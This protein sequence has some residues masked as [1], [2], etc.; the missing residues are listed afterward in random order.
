MNNKTSKNNLENFKKL[1]RKSVF[2]NEKEEHVFF[3]ISDEIWENIFDK[4]F[5]SNFNYAQR[6]LLKEFSNIENIDFNGLKGVEKYKLDIFNLKKCSKLIVDSIEK[7]I[8]ILF[9]TD[10]DN[11]GSLSQA[12][13]NEFLKI[14]TNASSLNNISVEYANPTGGNQN[15][16]ITVDLIDKIVENKEWDKNKDFLIITADNG[17]N[18]REEQEKINK[19]YENAKIIITDHHNP[20]KDMVIQ[21]NEKTLIFNPKYK[22]TEF[23]KKYNISG[24]NTI[25]VLLKHV[26]ANRYSEQQLKQ[27]SMRLGIRNINKLSKVSN[28][29]DYVASHPADKPEKDYVVSK[30]LEL[31][32]LL[33]INNSINKMIDGEIN[34]DTLIYLK[35]KIKNLNVDKLIEEVKNIQVQNETAK[36]LLSIY[37]KT[38]EDKTILK[39]NFEKFFLKEFNLIFKQYENPFKLKDTDVNYISQLRPLIFN[40]TADDEKNIFLDKL[41]E[42]MISIYENIRISEKA[43]IQEIRNGEV[44]TKERLNNSCIIYANEHVLKVFNRKFLNKVY[45]DE[46]P[47]FM[48]TLD[49]ISNEKR[50]GSFRSLYDISDILKNKKKLEKK[51]NITIETP[52]HERAA[53]FIIRTKNKDKAPIT[54]NTIKQINEFINLEIEELKQQQVLNKKDF[55]LTDLENIQ[56]ID[57]INKTI[58]GNIPH[59]ERITPL[60]KITKDTIWSES[61]STQ[62]FTMEELIKNKSYGYITININFHQDTVIVPVEVLR[63]IVEN[64]YQE[65]LSL[66]Y[67]DAGVFMVERVVKPEEINNLIDV[68]EK[69]GK[70]KEIE[71][72]FEKDFKN[73]NLIELNRLQIKDNPF[74]K[75]HDYGQLN[76]DLFEKMVIGIIETNKVDVLSVFDVEANGFGNARLTNLGSMNYF[77]DEN[78]GMKVS[79]KEFFDFYFSTTRGEDFILNEMDTKDLKEIK[80]EDVESLSLEQKHCLLIKKFNELGDEKEIYQYF[81]FPENKLKTIGKK[82]RLPFE[83]NPDKEIHNFKEV[84]NEIIYNRSI[85]AEMLAYLIK[86]KDFKVGQE[87]INLTG[88]TQELLDKHG[89]ETKIVDEDFSN[90]YKEKKARLFGAHNTPY[91]ARIIRANMPKTYDIL[92]NSNIYDSALFSKEQQLAYDMIQCAVF[93]KG[94]IKG[95]DRNTIYFYHSDFSEFNLK[96]FIEKNENGYFP[97]RSGRYLLEINNSEYFLVDKEAHEKIKLEGK[98]AD[99]LKDKEIN[100][101]LSSINKKYMINDIK[102]SELTITPPGKVVASVLKKANKL[103]YKNLYAFPNKTDTFL[104]EEENGN[105]LI[106][107]EIEKYNKK[108]YEIIPL[109]DMKTEMLEAMEI[110]ALPKVA[111]KYSVEK[112][113]EQW[114]IRAL[115][116]SD[117]KFD[118]KFKDINQFSYPELIPYKKEIDFFQKNYHFDNLPEVNLQKF[119]DYAKKNNA[120]I[121]SITWDEE[122]L[123]KTFIQEFVELNKD[124]QKKFA[125]SWMYKKVL[126]I[127]DPNATEITEDLISMINYQTNIPKEKIKEIYQQAIEF[128]NKYKLKHVLQH[129]QHVNGLWETDVKGDIAFEDKLTLSMLAQR[130]YD[131]FDHDE[132]KA[133]KEFNI[134]QLNARKAFDIADLLSDDFAV[135]SYSYRQGLQYNRE[136]QTNLIA[137]IQEKETKSQNNEELEIKFK[138]GNDLLPQDYYITAIKRD[139]VNLNRKQI[140]EDQRMIQF[141]VLDRIVKNG[142]E[143]MKDETEVNTYTSEILEDNERLIQV[144]KEELYAR[145]RY[146]ELNDKDVNLKKMVDLAFEIMESDE[147][148]SKEDWDNKKTIKY[149]AELS[150]DS[151]CVQSESRNDGKIRIVDIPLNNIDKNDMK[152]IITIVENY[153][154]N[155]ER[156]SIKIEQPKEVL[157]WLNSIEKKLE[158]TPIEKVKIDKTIEFSQFGEIKEENFINNIENK[159]IKPYETIVNKF[160]EQRILNESVKEFIDRSYI[161]KRKKFVI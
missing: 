50:S 105:I 52:G 33:N 40:L 15:R 116:L 115:L 80:T 152:K 146:I 81:L 69:N 68:S 117:E 76:F 157:Q 46:N 156:L 128:K 45:N 36:V 144:Y 122:L 14:D 12:I 63:R 127:K 62:Q 71:N 83:K 65:Y 10:V 107:K 138:L 160:N 137:N 155:A 95:I 9:V 20:E 120:N 131:P 129:E 29:L 109:S 18:S 53:G 121:T 142:L 93:E 23:F 22:P 54:D 119:V 123:L 158:I 161:S 30:F 31:Q 49:G 150:D 48:L 58:R 61:Y 66:N 47:G 132:T 41:N 5:D 118:I 110:K 140:E 101:F 6:V 43:I 39:E 108:T 1:V 133:I 42:K 149:I 13:I 151:F 154:N 141:L 90:Y 124:I 64:N 82:K 100:G 135:D 91:D 57:K 153:I 92:K 11:D 17:I 96:K 85:K 24:A 130:N 60:I 27:D 16:G 87:V 86:D 112:M 7:K 67:M 25:S 89:K 106:L 84:N 32:P 19:K 56:I 77:I 104:L 114:M 103:N 102:R 38:Q 143:Y 147:V 148:L 72:V 98:A 4:N 113:S 44:I 99:L 88:I 97:D 74:F 70:T 59:F 55:I 78:S 73:K 35:D 145:Y 159:T 28:V 94:K 51:L 2:L 139:G 111:V 26:L 125:D 8:P 37:N 134:A 136:E 75:Y 3:G 21:E 34:Q 79:K 126:S